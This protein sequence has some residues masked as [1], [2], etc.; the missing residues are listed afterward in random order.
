M[1]QSVTEWIKL[2]QNV[3]NCNQNLTKCD[4]LHQNVTKC[5]KMYQNVSACDKMYQ[6][7]SK[8]EMTICGKMYQHVSKCDTLHQKLTKCINMYLW[9]MEASRTNREVHHRVV[10]IGP[11][12]HDTH[13]SQDLLTFAQEKYR[14]GGELPP[15]PT[16][17]YEPKRLN[18]G[19]TIFSQ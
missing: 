18:S 16:L 5:D 9:F 15:F 7:V 12:K 11:C 14:L 10:Q 1:Y 2:H 6:N 13:S 17:G 4:T 3:T 8:C 19:Y